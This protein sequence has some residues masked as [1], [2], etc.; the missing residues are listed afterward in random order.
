MYNVSEMHSDVIFTCFKIMNESITRSKIKKLLSGDNVKTNIT[1]TVLIK[2][3]YD[4]YDS[5]M[6]EGESVENTFELL[7]V[8]CR[9]LGERTGEDKD[10]YR[11]EDFAHSEYYVSGLFLSA[12]LTFEDA[13]ELASSLY[14]IIVTLELC[15]EYSSAIG[16]LLAL[17]L[18]YDITGKLLLPSEKNA[19]EL[20]YYWM[21][22]DKSCNK[23]LV[24]EILMDS[25]VEVN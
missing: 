1:E 2:T 16:Y 21:S 17:V 4:I 15:R 9:M 8:M 23:D 20:S 14:C 13:V 7:K 6:V 5:F 18:I 24:Y 19:S 11:G 25:I 3:F 12:E 22:E 10:I